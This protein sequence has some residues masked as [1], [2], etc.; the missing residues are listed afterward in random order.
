MSGGKTRPALYGVVG[1]YLLYTAYG[2]FQGMGDPATKMPLV[3]QI[4]FIIFFAAA[5]AGLLYA[6]VRMWKRVSREESEL[7]ENMREERRR[8]EASAGSTDAAESED[9]P[10][11]KNPVKTEDLPEA[12]EENPGTASD[13]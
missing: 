6:A 11:E 8:A 10:S 3:V 7:L 2:L 9:A 12:E 5:G 1:A 4:L 13:Q